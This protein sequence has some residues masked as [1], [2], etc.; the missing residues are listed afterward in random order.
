[1]S[2]CGQ[3]PTCILSGGDI[4][5][6]NG[7]YLY[8]LDGPINQD[9]GKAL[10]EELGYRAG[11]RHVSHLQMFIHRA[12]PHPATTPRYARSTAGSANN[13]RPV[14]VRVIRPCSST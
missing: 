8:V 11:K 7:V 14:P 5:H 9:K 1:V 3:A 6:H 12:A 4:V 2:Q 10:D 13:S